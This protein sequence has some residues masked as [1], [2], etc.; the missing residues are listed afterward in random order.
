[1]I[2]A[3]SET[4]AEKSSFR[5]AFKERRCVVLANGFYEW[6]RTGDNG[7]QLYHIRR[8]KYGRVPSPSSGSERAGAG[9]GRRSVPALYSQQ[10]PTTGWERSATR[11]P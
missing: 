1:M 4:V 11:W 2:I 10:K 6:K 3:R 8:M 7:K 9:G 5:C